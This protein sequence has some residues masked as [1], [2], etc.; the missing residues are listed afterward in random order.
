MSAQVVQ[1]FNYLERAR[2]WT[3]R[4]LSEFYRVE[5]ALVQA[6]MA[7]ETER[8]V[9]DEGEP[10]FVFCRADTGEAFIHFARVDGKYIAV[11]SAL[12]QVVQGRDFTALV[13]E[14]LAGQ[15]WIMAKARSR[16]N[17]F[18]HPSALLIAIVGA[19]FFHSGQAKAGESHDH[20][21][22][23]VRKHVLPI[24]FQQAADKT[25][26]LDAGETTAI[27]AS[28]LLE[29]AKLSPTIATGRD[30]L[31]FLAA[32]GA[33]DLAPA[34]TFARG[35]AALADLATHTGPHTDLAPP[36]ALITH[37]IEAQAPAPDLVAPPS[38]AAPSEHMDVSAPAFD[39]GPA[40]P[41][42]ALPAAPPISFALVAEIT[43]TDATQF[44]ETA[45]LASYLAV[46][47][48]SIAPS[49]A[50]ISL[51]NHGVHE[52]LAPP[53]S[54]APQPM[55]AASL[56]GLPDAALPPTS[57]A[58]PP[59]IPAHVMAAVQQFSAEVSV[60]DVS[61][62]GHE[63]ILY[64]GAIFNHLPPGTILESMTFNFADGS[65]IALVGTAAELQSLHL[66]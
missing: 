47:P 55:P 7:L 50:L 16:S 41:V 40:A 51:V 35:A 10:W 66:T 61:V 9:T 44:V 62:T 30:I 48:V 3:Q 4:E 20:G 31:P 1:L 49:A 60:L 42:L 29:W 8:G 38:V 52:T 64:D 65:S 34:T 27:V 45:S 63:I 18:L 5:A 17:V 39:S 24:L 58:P 37:Q 56:P 6:G 23:A 22:D 46:Q 11:G 2:D 33:A 13:Q 53:I 12:D 28:V 15:A 26:P 19:A 36:P 32:A 25:A 21:R 14:I 59:L 54:A 43:P 57:P